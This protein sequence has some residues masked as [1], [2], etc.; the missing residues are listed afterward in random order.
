MATIMKRRRLLT[1][2]LDEGECVALL[3]MQPRHDAAGNKL[4]GYTL[5]AISAMAPGER[6]ALKARNPWLT[7]AEGSRE[8][9]QLRQIF[10]RR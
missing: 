3:L 6:T 8:F 1:N 5:E 10:S 7:T 4:Q 2:T 9:L